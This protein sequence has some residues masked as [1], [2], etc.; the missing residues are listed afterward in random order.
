MSSPVTDF[1]VENLC[2]RN[3]NLVQL[4]MTP[5]G[6]VQALQEYVDGMAKAREKGPGK[7]P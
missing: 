7:K 2:T 1:G 3:P 5:D 6:E 4:V